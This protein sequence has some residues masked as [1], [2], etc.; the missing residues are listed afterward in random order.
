MPRIDRPTADRAFF[1]FESEM[2]RRLVVPDIASGLVAEIFGLDQRSFVATLDA[3]AAK[4][5]IA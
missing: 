4:N 3:V 1:G 5:V 2:R